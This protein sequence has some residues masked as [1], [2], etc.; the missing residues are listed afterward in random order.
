MYLLAPNVNMLKYVL[1]GRWW[2]SKSRT[3]LALSNASPYQ[4]LIMN[5][6]THTHT[7]FHGIRDIKKKY[8]LILSYRLGLEFRIKGQHTSLQEKSNNI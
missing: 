1:G 2:S 5:N 3:F 4:R 8:D 7:Y 6:Y